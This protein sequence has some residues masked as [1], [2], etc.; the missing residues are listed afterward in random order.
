[1]WKTKKFLGFEGPDDS[2]SAFLTDYK[3]GGGSCFGYIYFYF[4]SFLP[5]ELQYSRF[6][7]LYLVRMGILLMSYHC[8]HVRF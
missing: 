2:S 5:R 7:N 6:L 3:K 8:N 4:L 1:M